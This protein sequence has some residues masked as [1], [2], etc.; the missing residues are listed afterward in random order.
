MTAENI[1]L[2]EKEKKWA[3]GS[4]KEAWPRQKRRTRNIKVFLDENLTKGLKFS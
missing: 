3:E 1:G 4:W 2:K